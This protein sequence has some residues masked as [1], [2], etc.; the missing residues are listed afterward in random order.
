MSN[1]SKVGFS[2]IVL[3]PLLSSVCTSIE[4]GLYLYLN[5]TKVLLTVATDSINDIIH[6]LY[7]VCDP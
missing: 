6:A 3:Y 2:I 1:W 7:N 4:R 5:V